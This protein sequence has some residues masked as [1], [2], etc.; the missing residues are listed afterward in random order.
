MFCEAVTGGA[1]HER[2][3]E[4]RQR[5]HGHER[6][7]RTED[8]V[9]VARA[10][11]RGGGVDHVEEH[12]RDPDGQDAAPRHLG[13][14]VTDRGHGAGTAHVRRSD[15]RE[16]HEHADNRDGLE[17]PVLREE[18]EHRGCHA[19]ARPR[20][21]ERGHDGAPVGVLETDPL[22]VGACVRQSE[23]DSVGA[24]PDSQE[25]HRRRGRHRGDAEHD[26]REAQTKRQ[27]TPPTRCNALTEEGTHTCAEDE[28]QHEQGEVPRAQV[29]ALL[30]PRKFRREQDEDEPL[31][32]EGNRDRGA[33][34]TEIGSGDGTHTRMVPRRHCTRA[35]LVACS[36]LCPR[37]GRRS[38]VRSVSTRKHQRPPRGCP[39]MEALSTRRRPAVL[40]GPGRSPHRSGRPGTSR[41]RA[42]APRPCRT[43]RQPAHRRAPTP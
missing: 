7:A 20:G 25:H 41:G 42:P 34:S 24:H 11:G 16:R 38:L 22:H 29:E 35:Q 15:Q 13:A 26:E 21:V 31:T 3:D 12:H 23:G 9:E 43:R 5:R 17:T 32:G 28:R 19:T 8:V 14:V 6:R 33:T 36:R 10:P 40:E 1:S 30:K 39:L 4:V 18:R 2:R 37:L 27:A